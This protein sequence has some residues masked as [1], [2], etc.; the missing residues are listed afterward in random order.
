MPEITR[1]TQKIFAS[2]AVNNG[3]FGSAQLGTKVLSNDIDTIQALSA[4]LNGWNDATISGQKLPTLEEMQG[5]QYVVTTQLAYLFE[6]GIPEYDS[7]T[8]YYQNSIV[9]KTGTYELY[10]SKTDNNAGNA[11]PSQADNTDWQYLLDL[12]DASSASNFIWGGTATGT[13]TIAITPAESPAAYADGQT[14]VFI[15]AN[16]NTGSVTLNVDSLG[17]I[18]ILKEGGI[19]LVDNDIVAGK[20]CMVTYY[21][22]DFYIN[23]PAIFGVGAN[24]A[25]ASTIDLTSTTGKIIDITG[26]TGIST[27]TLPEGEIRIARFTAAL[28]LTDSANLVL[29]SGDDITTAAGD[30]AIFIG[31]AS[32]VVRVIYQRANGEPL[33]GLFVEAED[34]VSDGYVQLSNGLTLQWGTSASIPAGSTRTVTYPV[35]FTNV[36]SV[37]LSGIRNASVNDCPYL[38]SKNNANFVIQGGGTTYTSG[39]SWFAIGVI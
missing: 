13:N 19:A 18:D 23:N 39:A 21:D 15:P 34:L 30:I 24:V 17:A 6:K 22:G 25:S 16:N 7:G 20:P 27:I 9:R 35:A 26:T 31:Y 1:K 33:A 4:W 8:E 14:F 2:N 32:G 11:L 12:A 29:P 3:Q 28:T 38:F 10:G 37:V 5:I 36:F